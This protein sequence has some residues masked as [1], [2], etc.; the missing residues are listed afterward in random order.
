MIPRASIL[1]EGGSTL[2]RQ[3]VTWTGMTSASELLLV[4]GIMSSELCRLVSQQAEPV[5]NGNYSLSLCIVHTSQIFL[6]SFSG[7]PIR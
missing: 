5:L 6:S 3:T 2:S 4:L 1:Y 7:C